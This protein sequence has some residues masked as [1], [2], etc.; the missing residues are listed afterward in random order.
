LG[1][2]SAARNDVAPAS[3]KVAFAHG[4]TEAAIF[5]RKR[6]PPTA[7]VKVGASTVPPNK[8]ATRWLGVWLDSQLTLKEH[9]KNGK[10]A[11]ACILRL[12]FARGTRDPRRRTAAQGGGRSQGRGG[13]VTAW[14]HHV[15]GWDTTGRWCRRLCG[16]VEVG[17]ILGEHQNSHGLQPG[18]LRCGVRRPR[19]G[20]G[21]R[22]EKTD[23]S[24]TSRD[25]H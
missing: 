11:M 5:R 21:D 3:N 12:G 7:T 23:D 10:N 16:C 14:T 2:K 20:A 25:L 18:G 22:F 4:K 17:P 1:D 8:E 24:G 19:Q 15:R 6:T 9:Q 13:E